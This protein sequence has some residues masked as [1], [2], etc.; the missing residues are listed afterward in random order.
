[1]NYVLVQPSG[2]A[3]AAAEVARI[4]SA[5]S[6]ADSAAAG[7]TT[8]V[9]AAAGDEVSTAVATLLS[10]YGQAYRA[11]LQQAATLHDQFAAALATAGNTYAATEAATS[12]TLSTIEAEA[13]ALLGGAAAPATATLAGTL[14]TA[15]AT[16]ASGDPVTT[17]VLGASGYPI[18]P[19]PIIDALAS[20]Y[21]NPP[22][23]TLLGLR[24]PEQFWPF[25]PQLGN[26]T[27]AQSIAQGVTILNNEIQSLISNASNTVNVF[28]YSQSAV[29]TSLEMQLLD[30]SNLPYPLGTSIPT[31]SL[32]FSLVGDP[33]NPNGGLLARFPGLSLPSVGLNFGTTTPANS[34]PTVIHTIEYDG[35]ADFPQYPIDFLADLNAFIGMDT[36]HVTY[37]FLTA[38][39]VNGAIPL[40][41][42]VGPTQ[43]E[44]FIIP[45]QNLPLLDPVRAIPVIGNPIADL[46]QPDLKVLV[47]LGYGSTT[48]GWSSGPPNVQT[49]F[50]VIPP[51]SP[52]AIASALAS[53]TQQGI[54]AFAGDIGA[55][56][57]AIPSFPGL[58]MSS[59]T[60]LVG[61]VGTGGGS[62]LLPA[63]MSTLSSPDSIATALQS[64]C[65]RIADAISGSAA[66]VYGTVLPTAAI[67]N[68][69]FVSVP[70]YDVQLFLNGVAEATGG[71]PVG[72]LVYAFGAPIAA[73]TA[74]GTMAGG[75][76]FGVIAGAA[77][78][79]IGDFGSLL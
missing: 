36:L 40:T 46:V 1:M 51:V 4:G 77:G 76:E 75:L 24:T 23:G 67:A 29:I 20:L 74:L 53:G 68:A 47:D 73:D 48:Q 60:S 79:I 64:E 6:A 32:N 41:N 50:G 69:A 61:S 17:V 3:A 45:T 39:Q 11:V 33:A 31:G 5:I 44:Y 35:Y 14:T 70:S 54:G 57:A 21:V 10:E 26:L 66:A 65:T 18:F 38:T 42:T 27:Y 56:V 19:Q 12:N 49:P 25:S 34:F 7:S 71:D 55:E 52:V 30:P 16:V 13:Q 58:V 15:V 43:T 2:L 22:V 28:G 63:L 78:T 62:S 59:A 8:G 37:P 9:L 72:G